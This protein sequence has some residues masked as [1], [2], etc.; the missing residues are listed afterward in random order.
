MKRGDKTG[1]NPFVGA[2]RQGRGMFL[3]FPSWKNGFFPNETINKTFIFKN[4]AFI[5]KNKTFIFKNRTFIYRT[6]KV[7][8]AFE[9]PV[10]ESNMYFWA[11]FLVWMLYFL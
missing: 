4:S 8:M 11:V 5:F 1:K 9:K 10:K 2:I 6:G 3:S 7:K